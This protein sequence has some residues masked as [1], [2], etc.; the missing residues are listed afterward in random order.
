MLV[1]ARRGISR[2][3]H[4]LSSPA[5]A[6]LPLTEGRDAVA[7]ALW[8]PSEGR[9]LVFSRD[10]GGNEAF[11]L[12]RLQPGDGAPLAL[13]PAGVRVSEFQFL[14]QGQGLVFLVEQL[15]RQADDLQGGDRRP[16]S[17]LLWVDP[18]KPES[19]RQLGAAQGGRYT[20]LRI[21]PGGRIVLALTQNGKS[22]TLY[23]TLNGRGPQFLGAAQRS[24]MSED[25]DL[26]WSRQALQGEFRHLVALDAM[27]ARRRHLLTGAAA[28]LEALA[29][30]A[31]GS[32]WPLALV[33]NE[34]GI[35]VLRLFDPDKD[36][37]PRRIATELPPG[38]LQH[39]RWHPRLPLL[40]FDHVSAES[41][42]RL[43]CWNLKDEQLQAWNGGAEDS[44]LEPATFNTLRWQSFDG[45]MIS[46]LH[47]APP[48]RFKGPRPVYINIHGGPSSQA[49]PGY[50]AGTLKHLVQ[51]FG[52]HI[53]EPNVRGSEGFGKR[54]LGLDNGRHR[55]DAVQDISA[56]LDLIAGR[57][58]M[59]ASKVIV[60][61]GSY[62][63]Y[64]SLAVATH[65]SKRIAGSICRVGI[66]NF[67][68]FLENTESYRRDNRRAEYGDERDPAMRE[69]LQKISP[70]SH[71][72]QVKKPLLVVHGR[73]DPRVPYS[74]A[75]A[76][77]KAVR[78]QGTPVWFLTAEDEGHSFS[79]ADNREYLHQLTLEFVQR[80]LTGEALQ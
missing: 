40:A 23:F 15:D 32:T 43:Y 61:G 16:F 55:E 17:R 2:Q 1:L 76:M 34:D 51:A 63:G 71:A 78:E 33:S 6:L 42:G 44:H 77:V 41:P 14:P 64:M 35:S 79:K 21:S 18:L 19:L 53:I 69:F 70:L 46:G 72:A 49:R 65:E 52:V 4:I 22:Q 58:D 36:E 73:N 47:I 8:E 37:S 56:L 38:V 50:L 3:L 29:V 5:T 12:F 57:E 80:L 27:S 20:G 31:P 45:L 59:D 13:T 67:V 54:F 24:E 7:D 60:A 9:Y 68:S 25:E 26:L 74:E 66:A 28:D 10:Q 11:Q 39:P 62:G 75:Q 30:P 48:A